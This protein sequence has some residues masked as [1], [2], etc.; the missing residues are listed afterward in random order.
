MRDKVKTTTPFYCSPQNRG[1]SDGIC[2]DRA[3]LLHLIQR[4]NSHHADS[5]M[6]NPSDSD[7]TLIKK[8][9]K[10][11][12]SCQGKGDWCWADQPFVENDEKIQSYYKP[13]IPS[14]RY[15]WLKTT[16]IDKV[17]AQYQ[18]VYPDFE[19]LGTV[20]LDFDKI[21]QFRFSQLDYCRLYHTD[22]KRKYGAVFNLDTS[23]KKGSHWVSMF[24]DLDRNFI[25]FFDS[26]G[27]RHPPAEIIML[28]R[29][30]KHKFEKCYHSRL[31]KYVANNIEIQNNDRSIQKGNTECGIFS[32]YFIIACLEGKTPPQ[33]FADPF[34]TD[35]SV[36]Y[37]RTKVFRPSLSSD[38]DI[39]LEAGYSLSSKHL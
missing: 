36:N 5:I 10:K 21:R 8:I 17:M 30:I 9:H 24:C 7:M 37:F 12:K 16:D 22:G 4:Y 18:K 20:P 1:N 27:V 6:V 39:F 19:Y 23:D 38:N 2:L 29:T 35:A 14:K 34:L 33:I 15:Q 28:M 13:K 32:L 3:G 31:N 26:V 11:L 25:A